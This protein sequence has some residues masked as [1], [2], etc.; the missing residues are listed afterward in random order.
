MAKTKRVEPPVKKT[1]A[2]ARTDA[3]HTVATSA[4]NMVGLAVV[5]FLFIWAA[6]YLMKPIYVQLIINDVAT[7][8]VYTGKAALI[9]AISSLLIVAL[10]S[11]ILAFINKKA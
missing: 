10:T 1:T 4:P 11:G 6:L 7:G 2:A 3:E 8:I 9:A 5:L